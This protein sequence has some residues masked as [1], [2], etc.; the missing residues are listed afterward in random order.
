LSNIQKY[1]QDYLHHVNTTTPSALG[2]TDPWKAAER[3][4]LVP[5]P[6]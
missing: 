3:Y 6:H 2:A 1:R 4:I 5:L